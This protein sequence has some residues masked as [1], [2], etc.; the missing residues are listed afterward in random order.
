MRCSA[1]EAT[2]L[3]LPTL[4]LATRNRHKIAEIQAVLGDGA[5]CL[6]L[7]DLPGSPSVTEDAPT[8]AGNA[9]K[10]AETLAGW[11]RGRPD[12]LTPPGTW[13]LADDSG[14]EVDALGGLP[15]VHSA[16]FAALE[17]HRA[18]NA[19]DAENNAKLLRLLAGVASEQRTARFRCAV[20]LASVA[21][22]EPE[23]PVPR[24]FEGVCEGRVLL[25]PRGQHGFGYD[26]L[27]QPLGYDATF[28]ELGD[29]VKNHVSHRARALAALRQWLDE[30][31]QRK[32]GRGRS[33]T[34]RG[35]SDN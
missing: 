22:P 10:K 28:A 13:V 7:A 14:L 20:A 19:S 26:P 11:L 8:F 3:E 12:G 15:G 5:R 6:S 35:R 18:G 25:S 21:N 33:G 31:R 2:G 34:G 30:N 32:S 1:S 29:A 4:V 24:V 27:F 16:R 17:A 23:R 9:L